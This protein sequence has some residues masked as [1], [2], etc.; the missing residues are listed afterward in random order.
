MTLIGLVGG[1]IN[2]IAAGGSALTLPALVVLGIPPA[3]ANGTN[4]VALVSSCVTRL[5]VF[6]RA[7]IIDWRNGLRLLGP[8]ALGAGA[9]AALALAL[10]EG[11]SIWAIAVSIVLSLVLVVMGVGKMIGKSV[12]AE[13]HVRWAH[14]PLFGVIG[15]WGG[16]IAVESA[17]FFLWAL[18]VLV[19]Y[20]LARGNALKALLMLTMSAVS[21]FEFE[22]HHQVDMLAGLFLSAG[23]VVGSW[24]GARFA[25]C[26]ASKI[27]VWRILLAVAPI[28]ILLLIIKYSQGG[29]P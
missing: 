18:V 12:H 9:G 4:R 5:V 8:V 19:G 26:E 20:G 29:S 15:A 1:F 11:A 2:A 24:A 6:Q 22:K 23:S 10:S 3:M 21:L 16:F 14:L 28:E 13:A 27:W 17:T 25:C 7:G